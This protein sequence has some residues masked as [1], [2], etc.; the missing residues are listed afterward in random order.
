[1]SLG[2][3]RKALDTL[4]A[5]DHVLRD[6]LQLGE[7]PRP[8]TTLA[9]A[10]AM[11]EQT[12][13]AALS[14]EPA[15]SADASTARARLIT[16]SLRAQSEACELLLRTRSRHIA[17]ITRS[18]T[19]MRAVSSVEALIRQTCSELTGPL[20]FRCAVYSIID[21]GGYSVRHVRRADQSGQQSNSAMQQMP[22]EEWRCVEERRPIVV[23]G[24]MPTCSGSMAMVLGATSYVVAPV[25]IGSEVTALIHAARELPWTV[26]AADAKLLDIIA[27]AFGVVYE[28]EVRTDRLRRQQQAIYTAARQLVADTEM[29]ADAEFDLDIGSAPAPQTAPQTPVRPRLQE[30]LT[31][32]EAEVLTLIVAGASNNEIA[33]QLVITV[34]TVKSH[35]KRVLRKLGA[36]NRA[37]AISLY[38]DDN[39]GPLPR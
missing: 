24:T 16:A 12:T 2:T 28:R 17:A 4:V 6:N 9:E 31:P 22:S 37:E 10:V 25:I 14:A 13:T 26:D 29:F 20:E 36:V 3:T 5:L 33:N 30:L 38:L 7:W 19:R 23:D 34:E 39:Q 1:M 11:S 18:I 15:G 27:S 21:C 35:V 32:R 8:V